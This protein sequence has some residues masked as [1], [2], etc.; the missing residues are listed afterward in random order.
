MRSSHQIQAIFGETATF[1]KQKGVWL[2]A[3]AFFSCKPQQHA[4]DTPSVAEDTPAEA[5]QETLTDGGFNLAEAVT[6]ISTWH[7]LAEGGE[8]PTNAQWGYWSELSQGTNQS[9]KSDFTESV[10]GSASETAGQHGNRAYIE[11]LA[12]VGDTKVTDVAMTGFLRGVIASGRADLLET[13]LDAFGSGILTE[14]ALA[15][16]GLMN[17]GVRQENNRPGFWA[18]SASFAKTREILQNRVPE[19]HRALLEA[20]SSDLELLQMHKNLRV[21][22]L[23]NDYWPDLEVSSGSSYGSFAKSMTSEAS[24]LDLDAQAKIFTQAELS[25]FKVGA[26]AAGKP[27]FVSTGEIVSQRPVT[28]GAKDLRGAVEWMYVMHEDGAIYVT[29]RDAT[30]GVYH[31]ALAAGKNPVA[32]GTFK[33]DLSGNLVEVTEESGHFKF[34]GHLPLVK[35]ELEKVGVQT[36]AAKFQDSSFERYPLAKRIG[37]RLAAKK[38]QIDLINKLN[39]DLAKKRAQREAA[40]AERQKS[41]QLEVNKEEV[42]AEASKPLPEDG[43]TPSK[44]KKFKTKLKS[45]FRGR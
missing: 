2:L 22:K 32:A 39:A 42:V 40:Q 3:L 26:N 15:T 10:L 31:S 37:A 33:F 14:K 17:Q 19:A 9:L 25:N 23:E 18:P 7:D 24:E 43:V 28:E 38:D 11:S 21:S 27:V 34:R 45:K 4:E 29:N 35:H 1:L 41:Q 44:W 8:S 5:A 20:T 30:A 36:Q 16:T 6:A 12:S 13:M